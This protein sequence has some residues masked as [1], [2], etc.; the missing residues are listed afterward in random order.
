MASNPLRSQRQFPNYPLWGS[1]DPGG[2]RLRCAERLGHLADTA[3]AG[4]EVDCQRE[5]A[6]RGV[7]LG[8]GRNLQTLGR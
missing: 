8:G 5:F 6:V 3:H 2:R 1:A 7:W 4:S